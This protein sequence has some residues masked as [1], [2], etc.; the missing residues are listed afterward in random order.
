MDWR[1]FVAEFWGTFIIVFAYTS[2]DGDPA[3]TAA[4]LMVAHSGTGLI[5]GCHFNPAVTLAYFISKGASK[6]LDSSEVVK[7]LLYI[8]VQFLGSFCGALM[9]WACTD[10][11][12][13]LE[14]G[15]Q[16]SI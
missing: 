6:S 11:T 13:I 2:T 14:V 8:P 16:S 12:V 9:T 1:H 7:F 15:S 5:S 4:G 3:A 10:K